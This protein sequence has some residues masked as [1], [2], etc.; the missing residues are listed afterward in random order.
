[1]I[2][3]ILIK[4]QII[5]IQDDNILTPLYLL[6]EHTG[7]TVSFHIFSLKSL[8]VF[9][10]TFTQFYPINLIDILILIQIINQTGNDGILTVDCFLLRIPDI[11]PAEFSTPEINLLIAQQFRTVFRK[12]GLPTGSFGSL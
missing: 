12:K 9:F 8:T 5:P 10:D 7:I 11:N 1:M 6:T 2:Q 4:I 3:F